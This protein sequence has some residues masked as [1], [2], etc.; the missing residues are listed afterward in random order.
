MAKNMVRAFLGLSRK[1]DT[2]N[3]ELFCARARANCPN[4]VSD[5]ELH[6][7]RVKS[8]SGDGGGSLNVAPLISLHIKTWSIQQS[9]DTPENELKPVNESEDQR[10]LNRILE[11]AACVT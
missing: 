11:V 6:T 8:V 7:S 4:V 2:E 5:G 1:K 10:A 3:G 9:E